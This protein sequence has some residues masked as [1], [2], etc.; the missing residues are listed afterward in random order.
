[1]AWKVVNVDKQRKLFIE[2]YLEE[3][4]TLAELCRQFDISR[5]SAYKWVDRYLEEGYEG[6][7]DRSR[8][9]LKQAYATDPLIVK[10]IL[11]VKY[12]WSTWGPKKIRGYLVVN[13]PTIIWPSNTTI[14]NIL[15][16]HGLTLPRKYRKRFAAKTDPLSHVNDSNDVWSVDFKGGW[17]TND[18]HKCEPFTLTDNYSRFLLRCIK[19]KINDGDHAW[20][21]L[22]V[23]F[24]E[25]GLPNSL[26]SDNGPPFATSGVGRLSALSIKLIKVGVMPEWIEPGNPQQ[27]GRHERMH[28]TL[29]QEGVF[30]GL[31]LKEQEKKLMIYQN[32]YNFERPHEALGQVTPG[33]VYRPSLRVWNGRMNLLEYP[34]DYKIGKIKSCG[35]MSWKGREIYVGRALAGEL[36]GLEPTEEGLFKMY[37]GPIFL[38]KITKEFELDVYRRKG[39]IRKKI[40]K[41]CLSK[42]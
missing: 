30:R 21:V 9:P 31:N 11:A 2:A 22:D 28:G 7:E 6:L 3:K 17:L 14:G 18:G 24:R 39:R 20:A 10:R 12:K 15:D 33:S 32:Y 23:A 27:N 29:Q 5:P 1:M 36:V 19:L 26:R 35:K 4:F 25:Y 13:E 37:F 41:N 34:N 8:A 16:K 42:T 38:G 40:P